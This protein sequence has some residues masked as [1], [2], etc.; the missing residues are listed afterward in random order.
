M[1]TMRISVVFIADFT[2]PWARSAIK[3]KLHY[4]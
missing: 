1:K 2:L 4:G 3:K